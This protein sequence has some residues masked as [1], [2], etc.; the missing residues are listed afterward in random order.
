MA[1]DLQPRQPQRRTG[2]RGT[3]ARDRIDLEGSQRAA[4]ALAD[5]ERKQ[6]LPGTPVTQLGR[7]R[8]YVDAAVDADDAADA[9][10]LEAEAELDAGGE[11]RREDGCEGGSR[12]GPAQARERGDL[13][14]SEVQREHAVD[15]VGKDGDRA[16]ADDGPRVEVRRDPVGRWRP[17]DELWCGRVAGVGQAQSG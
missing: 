4:G 14:H 5:V 16:V 10:E 12:A 17:D 2:H 8:G 9:R 13:D 7:Q 1:G 11:A 15:A 6:R 3:D